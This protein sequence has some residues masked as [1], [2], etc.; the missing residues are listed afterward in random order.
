VCALFGLPGLA[1]SSW[2]ARTPD[3]RDLVRAS[4]EQMGFV[5]FGV[6]VGSMAGIL[7][8]AAL[9]RRFGARGVT[10]AGMGC[11]VVSMP[12]VGMGAELGAGV[13]VA[14]GLG[15]FG[16]GMGGSE[17]AI[18]AEGAAI[19]RAAGTSVLPA[20][21]GCFSLGTVVGA[22]AGVACNVGDVPVVAHL[23]VVGVVGAPVLLSQARHLSPDTGRSA[24]GTGRV[25]SLRPGARPW[26]DRRVVMI[27]VV[28]LA[29]ALA[30]G[31][32][33]DWLPL[34]M[35]DGH[36]MSAA[37][38]SFVFAAFAMAMTVGRFGGGWF[39]DRY[40]R[41]SV[42]RSNACAA[43]VGIGCIALVDDRLVASAGVLLWG[44]GLSLGFPV[45]V[46]AAGDTSEGAAAR[47][48]FVTTMGYLAF[49]VG[50]PAL[51]VIGEDFGLRVALLVPLGLV[52]VA[53]FLAPALAPEPGL[54]PVFDPVLDP[55]LDPGRASGSSL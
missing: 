25:A 38:G 20:M 14:V 42:L 10:T 53:V 52:L 6:S 22:L 24:R 2:V 11:I 28:V 12:V 46:S 27:G 44:L 54:D 13:V 19:E 48:S 41:A 32:A 43:V 4:T 49:L 18:N 16:L 40:G 31:A 5:L 45:A 17:I 50:P 39:L 33:T 29:M 35:V 9:L 37:L 15:L 51:G 26:R 7:A 47:V 21:H 36:G 23:V 8:S 55:V 3:I 34:V 1:I 30:E